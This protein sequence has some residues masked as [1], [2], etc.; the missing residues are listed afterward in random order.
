MTAPDPLPRLMVAPNGA[1]RSK[2]DHPALPITLEETVATAVACQNT[3]AEGIHVHVR[4]GNGRH[5]IDVG[6]YREAI[7]A[8]EEAVPSMFLQ[9]TSEA[10][11]LYGPSD[12]RK[13]IRELCPRSVTVALRE[14]L[15]DA[16]EEAEA[17]AF[18]AWARDEGVSVQHIT[19]TP[20]ELGWL[21]DCVDNGVIPG[22][23]HQLQLALGSYAGTEPSRPADLDAFLALLAPRE[24]EMA[25]DWMLCAFGSAETACLAYAAKQG[26]KVRVGFE[27]SLWNADG[28]LAR[29]NAERVREVRAAIYGDQ[30]LSPS[31]R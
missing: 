20:G 11:G 28:S 16:S 19:Y 22:T 21:L 24:T 12:Q 3:G 15:S 13:M 2:A 30:T 9:V 14:M 18:Y 4:D 8:L 27:N 7:T 5:S 26:G 25:L 1:R 31:D 6:L 23:S 29:D 10:V 17:R